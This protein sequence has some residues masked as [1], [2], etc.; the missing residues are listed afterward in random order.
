MLTRVCKRRAP[1]RRPASSRVR[2][3]RSP[4]AP[5]VDAWG[6]PGPPE[7]CSVALSVAEQAGEVLAA[8]GEAGDAAE[9]VE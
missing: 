7:D 3:A 9:V 2:A 1:P 5:D 4:E 6:G 8:L